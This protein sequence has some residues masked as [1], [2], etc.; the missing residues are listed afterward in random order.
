MTDEMG[1]SSLM[2][3]A[4]DALNRGRRV[5]MKLD[6]ETGWIEVQ[7]IKSSLHWPGLFEVQRADDCARVFAPTSRL[8][9][10]EVG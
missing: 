7:A 10:I 6:G 3:A 9:A 5:A 2:C 8:V 1:A 4:L